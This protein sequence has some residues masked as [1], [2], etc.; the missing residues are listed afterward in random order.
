MTVFLVASGWSGRTAAINASV[1]SVSERIPEPGTTGELRDL[2]RTFNAMLGRLEGAILDL[3]NFAAD[4]AH[5][6][7]TPL[8][9]LR[10]EIETA[11]QT[12]H[13]PEE[14]ERILASFQVEVARMTRVVTEAK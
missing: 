13:S 6:L 10:A 4:A 1:T 3:E 14:H 11:I 5:E 9:T 2:V 8:A 7:R 12:S